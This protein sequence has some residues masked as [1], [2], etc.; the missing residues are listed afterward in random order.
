MQHNN[1]LKVAIIGS[2]NLGTDLLYKVLR[3]EHLDCV[4]FIGRSADSK[5]LSRA[6]NLGVRTSSESIRAI[7]DEKNNIDLVFDATSASQHL[8]HA[9]IFEKFNIKAI[10]LTPAKLGGFCIPSIN[11]NAILESN[12]INMVT[13]GGQ[14]SIPIIKSMSDICQNILRVE[15]TSYLAE[16]SVGQGT[17]DNIDEYYSTTADAITEFSN[18]QNVEVKLELETSSWKPNMLTNIRF[19]LDSINLTK[20]YESLQNRLLQ[21]QQHVPG[22]QINGTPKFNQGVFDVSISV[23]GQGDWLPIHAGNLDII[24]CAAIAAAEHLAKFNESNRIKM[25]NKKN[26][27]TPEFS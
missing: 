21:I 23:S 8:I 3:S 14:S 20:V 15:L 16:D 5:G 18:I 17:I 4:L 11:I 24:N 10:D 25:Q 12:N 13:C 1:L 26:T 27:R 6:R 22:Y 19:H 2:G 7:E 9:P